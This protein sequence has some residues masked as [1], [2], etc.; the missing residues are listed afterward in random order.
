MSNDKG[1]TL[2]LGKKLFGESYDPSKHISKGRGGQ[3]DGLNFIR[4]QNDGDDVEVP[5]YALLSNDDELESVQVSKNLSISKDDHDKLVLHC[6]VLLDRANGATRPRLLRR[7]RRVLREY[8]A[9]MIDGLTGDEKA[10]LRGNSPAN[11]NNDY[12]T[13]P[14]VNQKINDMV[15][16]ISN[17]IFPPTGMYSAISTKSKMP[18]A[19]AVSAEMNKHA[20]RF[21]H[22]TECQRAVSNLLRY[23]IAALKV[24]WEEVHGQKAT[25]NPANGSVAFQRGVIFEGNL[26]KSVDPFN[27]FYDGSIL[28]FN[29]LAQNGEFV[30]HAYRESIFRLKARIEAGNYFGSTELG[31]DDKI[32]AIFTTA[33]P[34]FYYSPPPFDI[35][36][37]EKSECGSDDPRGAGDI[38]WSDV[39]SGNG[40]SSGFMPTGQANLHKYGLVEIVEMFVRLDA[41]DYGLAPDE[42][43]GT[44][45]TEEG[46]T[47]WRILLLNGR[48]IILAEPDTSPHGMLPIQVGAMFQDENSDMHEKSMAEYIITFQQHMQDMLNKLQLAMKKGVLGGLTIYNAKKIGLTNNNNP[49]GG[50]IPITDVPENDDIRRHIM[51]L[52]N[53]PDTART[54]EQIGFLTELLEQ[55][56]PTRQAQQVADLQRATE[57]QAAAT[58]AASSKRSLSLA[59]LADESLFGPIR[60]MQLMN[61]YQ[62]SAGIQSTDD[63]G[64][65]TTLMPAALASANLE[66]DIS[67]GLLGLDRLIMS[68]RLWQVITALIQSNLAASYDMGGLI[69]YYLTML[70]DRTDFKTFKIATPFD[71][72]PP[73][74]KQ[75]AVAALE[76]TQGAMTGD[77]G[78]AQPSTP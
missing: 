54:A 12:M 53:V 4:P 77:N 50:Y 41:D 27:L 74:Q 20:Q 59:K 16:I 55:I 30:A 63:A 23:N 52:S 47:V 62:Y 75:A 29:E 49:V 14:I 64:A 67:S 13:M 40:A 7:M 25:P 37:W 31:D 36:H 61:L 44:E 9:V 69:D 19:K 2:L 72:M 60:H 24:N 8:N 76:A 45:T 51:Q 43:T 33:Y 66:F 35:E 1:Y 48:R 17:V 78:I 11:N 68:N 73:K 42:A 18:I 65:E 21:A 58:I 22:F 56:A 28:N 3:I 71:G 39:A 70:G 32:N 46:V 10:E 5:T 34:G 57:F 26:V 15:S 38:N 6:R